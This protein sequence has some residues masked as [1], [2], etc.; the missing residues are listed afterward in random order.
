MVKLLDP[1]FYSS[2]SLN[3]SFHLLGFKVLLR[4]PKKYDYSIISNIIVHMGDSFSIT[5]YNNE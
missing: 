4:I 2:I 3:L 5:I 1:E